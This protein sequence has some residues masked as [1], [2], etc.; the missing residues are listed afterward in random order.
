VPG[1]LTIPLSHGPMNA[2]SALLATRYF[3]RIMQQRFNLGSK[4][5][6]EKNHSQENVED[7]PHSAIKGN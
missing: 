2:K 1:F 3:V 7:D 4:L 6:R 5:S